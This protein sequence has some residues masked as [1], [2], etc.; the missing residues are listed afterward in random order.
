MDNKSTRKRRLVAGAGVMASVV[1]VAS[2]L[3]AC[4]SGSSK[5]DAEP[6]DASG[7]AAVEVPEQPYPAMEA[8]AASAPTTV[9][10]ADEF[11]VITSASWGEIYPNEYMTYLLNADNVPPEY[12]EIT[13]TEPDV[14]S[15]G[16][17][18]MTD[19]TSTKVDYLAED[20]YPEIKT[21]GKGY[22]YAKYY[23][24]PA[25]HT[26]S[27]WTIEH[28]GRLGDVRG[29]ESK[30]KYSCYACKTPQQHFEALEED[31]GSGEYWTQPV[32]N[33][34][35]HFTEN[36]SCA[37]CHVNEDPTQLQVL[38][39]DWKRAMGD[40]ADSV[41]LEGQV[42]GQCHC[43]YSMA[44]TGDD[45]VA[46]Y[47]DGE[48]TSPYYGGLASMVPEQALQF[49]D[50]YNFADWVY[51]STGAKMLAVRHAEF[52]F[53][54]G[55]EGNYMTSIGYDCNDCH[56]GV[57]TAD[58]GTTYTSHHWTSPLENEELIANDCGRCHL[59][60][61]S[62][63]R[64]YQA[65]LDG[66]THEL[67]L[68]AEQFIFNF[69]DKVATEQEVDGEKALVFDMDTAKANGLTEEQVERLQTIQREACYYWNYVAAE[70]SEGC[71]NP[72]LYQEC[73]DKGN[74]LLDEADEILGVDSHV[75]A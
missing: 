45:A 2:L 10:E 70:N 34:V 4:S 1:V 17:E 40:D 52:E 59:D 13:A 14:T 48:P 36:I 28:N 35:D 49:Y 60:L 19:F 61:V 12:A 62:E 42:C 9:P 41:P 38:R 11:G 75:S 22:G 7:S 20:Q 16:I 23:T 33:G 74:A 51:Q 64:A 58:D 63:A 66:Q 31:D 15:V 32:G 71:H 27:L 50:E 56:M 65:D 8:D 18:D 57:A 44:P 3:F 69:E 39:A 68:R 29:G 43:D 46:P 6:S 5:T 30:G 55:G 73:I 21:L 37:N 24:E 53:N 67:G 26:Y 47:N 25:G 54:Y 72:Q